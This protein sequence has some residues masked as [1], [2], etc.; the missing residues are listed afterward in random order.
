MLNNFTILCVEDNE[1]ALKYIKLMLEDDV[2]EF[3][4]A[5]NGKD[6]LKMYE[7]K[8]P[9]IILT[10]INMPEMDGLTMI[11]R[12]RETN[13]NIPI[14]IISAFDDKENLLEAINIGGNGFIQKPIDVDVLYKKLECI[15][16]NLQDKID[17]KTL[18]ETQIN[19]LYNL[20][21]YDG[22][23][24]I[25]NMFLFQERLQQAISRS[26]RD[27]FSLGLFFIDLDNFKNVNDTF[28][29]KVGDMTL[30]RVVNNISSVIREEDVLSRRSGDEFLLLLEGIKNKSDLE[31]LANK[32]IKA[33]T[34]KVTVEDKS[35]S[36]SSSIG[37][38][39]YPKDAQTP[40]ELIHKA[41][42]AMYNVKNS[43]KADFAFYGD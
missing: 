1:D 20:A 9:D 18:K 16:R 41:D 42:L 19:N 37:I 15:A 22:L 27:N 5:T 7:E 3:Y 23:T 40:E 25:P 11:K 39:I 26:K 24:N 33:T 6:G 2:K 21:H 13:K 38:A 35:V 36:I 30:Q 14:L 17:A 12:I 28:G 32:I 4:M 43:G 34:M 31:V 8:M 29:H 10:D